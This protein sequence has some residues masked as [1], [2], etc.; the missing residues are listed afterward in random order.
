MFAGRPKDGQFQGEQRA[1]GEAKKIN[2]K[3]WREVDIV[4][5]LD[6]LPKL[7]VHTE[8]T[9][10]VRKGAGRQL[11]QLAINSK[12]LSGGRA[13]GHQLRNVP[14]DI[15]WLFRGTKVNPLALIGARHG[16]EVLKPRAGAI[17]ANRQVSYVTPATVLSL[18]RSNQLDA[19]R[20]KLKWL[21]GFKPL[22]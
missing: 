8:V 14:I 16:T 20:E 4:S 11:R 10:I 19:G 6:H 7:P 21:V 22:I 3:R 5:L 9:D 17:K 15:P 13:F 2:L 12:T 18:L 1:A